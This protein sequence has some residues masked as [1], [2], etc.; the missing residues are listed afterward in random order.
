M[1]NSTSASKLAQAT[2]DIAKQSNQY[3][4]SFIEKMQRTKDSTDPQEALYHRELIKRHNPDDPYTKLNNK[5]AH[6]SL[7]KKK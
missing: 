4:D 2:I 6:P 7:P 1:N 3:P 5:I